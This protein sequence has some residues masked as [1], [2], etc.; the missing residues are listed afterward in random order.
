MAPIQRESDL[1][2]TVYL[3]IWNFKPCK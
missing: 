3:I 2:V 1:F